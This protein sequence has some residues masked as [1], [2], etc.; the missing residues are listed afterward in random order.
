LDRIHSVLGIVV[1]NQGLVSHKTIKIRAKKIK[2]QKWFPVLQLS[3][4]RT[5]LS[6]TVFNV[7]GRWQD[8]CYR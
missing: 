3:A 5:L 4:Q 2:I 1:Q 7:C 8:C 6:D